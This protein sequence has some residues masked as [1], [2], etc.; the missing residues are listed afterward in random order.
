MKNLGWLLIGGAIFWL[1]WEKLGKKPA[2]T[3][4]GT[5]SGGIGGSVPT[6]NFYGQVGSNFTDESVTAGGEVVQTV[7][8]T[9]TVTAAP[10]GSSFGGNYA[11]P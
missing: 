2:V 8:T 10:K 9:T 1:L 6:Q 5:A 11:E 7:T 4:T 3:G